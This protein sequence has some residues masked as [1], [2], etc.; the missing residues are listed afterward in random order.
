MMT[1]LLAVINLVWDCLA[2][3]TT[4]TLDTVANTKVREQSDMIY[5]RI[6]DADEGE[7]RDPYSRLFLG[8]RVAAAR[9][10]VDQA[11]ADIEETAPV[12]EKGLI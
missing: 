8:R 10:P 1:G 2:G 12:L 9:A 6:P 3:P 5:E 4:H 7:G 11:A